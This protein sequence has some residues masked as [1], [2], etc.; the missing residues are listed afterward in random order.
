MNT[1]GDYQTKQTLETFGFQ[2][3]TPFQ[4]GLQKT[5]DWYRNN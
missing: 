1:T 2:A 3:S 5:V 4:E